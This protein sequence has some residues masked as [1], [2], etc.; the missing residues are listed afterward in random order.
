MLC[1]LYGHWCDNDDD[2]DVSWWNMMKKM[3]VLSCV[4]IVDGNVW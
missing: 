4:A 1:I 2:N 3:A